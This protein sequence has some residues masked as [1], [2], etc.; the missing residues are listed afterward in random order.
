ML[1][2]VAF[3]VT[4]L[5]LHP[6]GK[7]LTTGPCSESSSVEAGCTQI[8]N[9]PAT[10]R[11]FFSPFL[12]LPSPLPPISLSTLIHLSSLSICQSHQDRQP[13]ADI[14]LGAVTRVSLEARG[15]SGEGWEH[16]GSS[17]YHRTHTAPGQPLCMTSCF[18]MSERNARGT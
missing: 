5:C 11:S 9:L 18:I 2:Y 6:H 7:H 16:A 14:G 12:P 3:S 10:P 1:L 17:G 8:S 13:R 4:Q 15:F